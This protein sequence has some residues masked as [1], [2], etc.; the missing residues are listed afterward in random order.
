MYYH[1]F[2]DLSEFLNGD[3]AAKIW[4]MILSHDLIDRE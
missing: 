4:Q 2:K 3:V 1:I